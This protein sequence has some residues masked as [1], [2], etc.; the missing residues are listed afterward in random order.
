MACDIWLRRDYLIRRGHTP[1]EPPC[2]H[3][4]QQCPPAVDA[5][6][7]QAEARLLGESEER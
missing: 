7:Q 2:G 5:D 6:V 4:P 3:D 1:D